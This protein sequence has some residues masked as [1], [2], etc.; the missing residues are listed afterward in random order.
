[1][2]IALVS[3][4]KNPKTPTSTEFDPEYV[5]LFTTYLS[6]TLV[7]N[8]SAT[9]LCVSWSFLIRPESCH[10]GAIAFRIWKVRR[11]LAGTMSAS[12]SSVTS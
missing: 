7:A 11:T 6:L 2:G 4:L 9:G 10:L 12:T 5:V 1:M 8:A 3:G